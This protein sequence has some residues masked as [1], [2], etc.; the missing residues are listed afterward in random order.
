[1]TW[2]KYD[3][4]LVMVL[5]AQ[6]WLRLG[7]SGWWQWN[8][9]KLLSKPSNPNIS[10]IKASWCSIFGRSAA[11]FTLLFNCYSKWRGRAGNTAFDLLLWRVI[12]GGVYLS[13]LF[14]FRIATLRG[15]FRHSKW[16]FRVA[17]VDFTSCTSR[18][19]FWIK[20]L[21]INHFKVRATKVSSVNIC[22]T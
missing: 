5:H 15:G 7:M 11:I 14:S 12:L 1:M 19:A 20:P 18:V 22:Q 13:C 9:L 2:V 4:F 6:S 10:P 16:L 17:L 3:P 21:L 8:D